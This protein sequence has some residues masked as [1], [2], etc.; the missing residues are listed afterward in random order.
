M[1]PVFRKLNRVFSAFRSVGDK[2]VVFGLGGGG[3]TF[4]RTAPLFQ[5]FALG[6]LFNVGGYGSGE[7]RSS[8][9]V[10]SGFG[11]LRSA[12]TLPTY[13]GG[14]LYVGGF[15]EGG[16]A[17]ENWGSAKYRQSV[18]GGAVLETR[19]GPIFLGGSF[20]EGGRGKVYFSLG[21]FF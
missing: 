11:V 3:T 6:G 13:V 10:K 2:Y 7:F 20:A 1:G 19:L 16:S 21:R 15:Y 4:S 9:Y 12:Y 17:F 5:Q 8:N 14:K 18:T